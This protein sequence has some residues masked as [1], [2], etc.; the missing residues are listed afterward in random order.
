MCV[1]V[2][3]HDW[4]HTFMS[5]AMFD[6]QY[7]ANQGHL[8]SSYWSPGHVQG[9]RDFLKG[10]FRVKLNPKIW[11]RSLPFLWNMFYLIGQKHP[12]IICDIPLLAQPPLVLSSQLNTL[13]ALDWH[14]AVHLSEAHCLLNQRCVC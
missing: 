2:Y 13:N 6:T 3:P 4:G 1:C 11:V 7:I 8:L 5:V 14:L 12:G 9:F 10:P